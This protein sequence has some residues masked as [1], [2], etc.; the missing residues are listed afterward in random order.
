MP[1]SSAVP[2]SKI[3]V[4]GHSAGCH[5]VT[6]LALDPRYLAKVQA[7]SERSSRRGGLERR[8]LRSGGQGE[9]RRHVRPLYQ[10][11]TSAIRRPPGATPRRW[12]TSATPSRCRRSCSSR[13]SI[14]A[15][16]TRNWPPKTSPDLI[17]NAK[18]Q[19]TTKVLE[20]RTHTDRQRP[21]RRPQRHHGR[22]AARVSCEK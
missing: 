17:R 19:A 20:G 11:G 21:D 13:S 9:G 12:P 1:P 5:L 22:R 4:M 8:G 7:A 14:K 16:P 3:V 15:R 6:L 10:A 18:G 2:T